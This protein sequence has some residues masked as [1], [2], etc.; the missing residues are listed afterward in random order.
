MSLYARPKC[1]FC[2]RGFTRHSNLNYHLVNGVCTGK[3]AYN[4]LGDMDHDKLRLII[5]LKAKE[6]ELARLSL[7]RARLGSKESE[8]RVL[9]EATLPISKSKPRI[10]LTWK[11][12]LTNNFGQENCDIFKHL[13]PSKEITFLACDLLEALH[14]HPQFPENH[15]LYYR[16]PESDHVMVYIDDQ[17]Q[18]VYYLTLINEYLR[19]N[20]QRLEQLGQMVNG[21]VD[22]SLPKRLRL[23]VE[24]QLELTQCLCQ[25]TMIRASQASREVDSQSS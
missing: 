21:P 2:Q 23:E 4:E 15:N 8:T 16:D 10:R 11:K 7:E 25:Q 24:Q 6:I 17:W 14:Y 19:G 1:P 22:P 5:E 3:T 20:L 12:S 18:P 9:E 13:K